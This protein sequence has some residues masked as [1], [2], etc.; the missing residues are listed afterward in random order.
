MVEVD[1]PSAEGSPLASNETAVVEKKTEVTNLPALPAKVLSLITTL[2]HDH[3]DR[4]NL[5][6]ACRQLRSVLIPS[7]FASI[8]ANINSPWELSTL[9]YLFLANSGLGA[10]V[11]SLSLTKSKCKQSGEL[12]FDEDRMDPVLRNLADTKRQAG[13]WR[14]SL[15]GQSPRD[16]ERQN[17]AWAAIL[18]TLFP[19]LENLEMDWAPPR[20]Y[21]V[22]VMET[23]INR[24]YPPDTQPPFRRLTRVVIPAWK[25]GRSPLLASEALKFF[26]TLSLREFS[27]HGILDDFMDRAPGD[28][29]DITPYTTITHLTLRHSNSDGGF[30]E[31]I[32]AC[33]RLETFIY[34]NASFL[35]MG[36]PWNPPAI[37]KSLLRHKSSLTEI[38]IYDKGGPR[39]IGSHEHDYFGSLDEFLGLTNL[40]I[41]AGN[42]L[43][44][45]MSTKESRNWLGGVLPP[46]LQSL[47]IDG[48]NKCPNPICLIEQLEDLMRNKFLG[49]P[50]YLLDQLEIRGSFLDCTYY[51]PG[52]PLSNFKFIERGMQAAAALLALQCSSNGVAFTVVDSMMENIPGCESALVPK[53]CYTEPLRALSP[54]FF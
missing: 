43:D 40:R 14:D 28:K 47:S 9:V 41:P 13:K 24:S 25:Y 49:S 6:S 12:K 20:D 1:P 23:A 17:D 53:E 15:L 7:A 51:K 19:N 18:L 8:S 27:C 35:T 22:R 45:N 54:S 31:L 34:E 42:I 4:I 38:Q 5:A 2:L 37:Y 50:L 3:D 21:R 32:S 46:G 26:Q 30:V 52:E 16:K 10:A 39:P 44:W 36:E 29:K 48:F 33:E 11:K